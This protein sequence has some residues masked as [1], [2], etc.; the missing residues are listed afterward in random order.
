MSIEQ[1]REIA[2]KTNVEL[3]AF[4]HG[5]ICVCHSGRCYLS[6]STSSRSGNRGECS[7][8]CRLPY[9]LTDGRGQIYI[10][11]KHLLSVCD[12]DLS[13]RIGQLIDA[14]VNSF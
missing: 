9:D 13:E 14:G 2:S 5:A 4:I 12:L 7:Q 3:E 10:K 8:P 6:R 1:I 11:G